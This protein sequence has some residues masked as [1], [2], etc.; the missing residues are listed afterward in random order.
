MMSAPH[1]VIAQ[2]SASGMVN[3]MGYTLTRSIGKETVI[4]RSA[5]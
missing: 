2:S 4:L 1:P 3:A 5:E